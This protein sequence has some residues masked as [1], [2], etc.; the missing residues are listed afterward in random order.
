[1]SPR[2]RL[3]SFHAYGGRG[4]QPNC[5]KP[6][7]PC[8][9]KATGAGI[10]PTT[11]DYIHRCSKPLSYRVDKIVAIDIQHQWLW[12]YY[13]NCQH[14]SSSVHAGVASTDTINSWALVKALVYSC[15]ANKGGI[16]PSTS[17]LVTVSRQPT[18]DYHGFWPP[19]KRRP[20]LAGQ[21][22]T[23]HWRV[24]SGRFIL[25]LLH[26]LSDGHG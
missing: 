16:L 2:N 23:H 10:E 11:S 17:K 14:L 25:L 12:R 7:W 19:W 4:L 6:R 21:M 3:L 8:E 5:W 26:L 9:K 22:W 1:M 13:G 20:Y 15:E 18:V 24:H